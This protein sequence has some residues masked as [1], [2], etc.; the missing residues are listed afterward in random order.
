MATKQAIYKLQRE[1]FGQ[2]PN[3]HIK[4]GHKILKKRWTGIL[5]NR[6]Y[7][8]P[9]DSIARMVMPGYKTAQEERRLQKLDILRRRGKG[10]PKKGSGKKKKR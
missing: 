9:I 10:P 1:I 6:Y 8:D 5:D 7:L 3:K 4:T 2:L